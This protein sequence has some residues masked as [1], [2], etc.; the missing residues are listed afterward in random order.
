MCSYGRERL[1]EQVVVVDRMMMANVAKFGMVGA[2][3]R[4]DNS[5]RAVNSKTPHLVVFGV[6][7]FSPQRRMKRIADK[8][9]GFGRCFSLN[10]LG[11]VSEESIERGGRGQFDHDSL[12]KKGMKR[13]SFRHSAGAM[14]FFRGLQCLQKALP[15]E[16]H[17]IAKG[18]EVVFRNL[19][20][21]AIFGLFDDC[22]TENWRHVAPP[23]VDDDRVILGRIVKV[24]P[25]D[26]P[27]YQ[28][29]AAGNVTS[30]TDPTSQVTRF[31]YEPKFNRVAKITD[32]R[33]GLTRFAYGSQWGRIRKGKK[34]TF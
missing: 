31:E 21:N 15:V 22:R 30:L 29:D 8:E 7:F 19:D 23:A 10:V 27:A 20:L 25:I 12:R 14:I 16:A 32:A 17:G 26:T 4:E 5:I 33:H 13:L 18:F 9:I 3:E 1:F 34:G 11:E 24:N 28:Y 6:Q 2:D